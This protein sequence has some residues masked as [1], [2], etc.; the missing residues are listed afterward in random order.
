MLTVR[1][2]KAERNAETPSSET[3]MRAEG[4]NRAIARVKIELDITPT[5]CK[6]EDEMPILDNSTGG[7]L[8]PW[9]NRGAEKLHCYV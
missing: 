7:I 1:C 9:I 4:G 6:C 3:G 5:L 2:V 8:P